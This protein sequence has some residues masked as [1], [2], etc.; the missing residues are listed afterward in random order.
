MANEGSSASSIRGYVSKN[1]FEGKRVLMG[2]AAD[3]QRTVAVMLL[4]NARKKAVTK[5]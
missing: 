2:A 3:Q 1:V 4:K 5:A